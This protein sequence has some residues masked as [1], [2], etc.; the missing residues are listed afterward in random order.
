[1]W[2]N[3]WRLAPVEVASGVK[4][5][6][7]SA[8]FTREAEEEKPCETALRYVTGQVLRAGEWRDLLQLTDEAARRPD[9]VSPSY[10]RRELVYLAVLVAIL[11]SALSQGHGLGGLH[12]RGNR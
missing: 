1:L 9:E 12:F 8:Q 5:Q 7:R 3:W 6:V 11:W 2:W 4:V 10:V